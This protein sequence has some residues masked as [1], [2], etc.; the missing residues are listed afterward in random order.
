MS[1][2]AGM[3]EK[4]K[5]MTVA[6]KLS[7]I[8]TKSH[9]WEVMLIL[10]RSKSLQMR[11]NARCCCC[12]PFLPNTTGLHLVYV[13]ATN[14][15]IFLF[16]FIFLLLLLRYSELSA[17]TSVG[18]GSNSYLFTTT[19]VS[20]AKLYFLHHTHTIYIS[21]FLYFYPSRICTTNNSVIVYVFPKKSRAREFITYI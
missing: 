13:E 8:R 11:P 15:H 17:T 10:F 2:I 16:I 20:H 4:G 3:V 12:W 5:I 19:H 7:C 1:A 6:H 21:C 14:L 9:I 18:S